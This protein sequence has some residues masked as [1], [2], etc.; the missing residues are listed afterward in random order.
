MK[1]EPRPAIHMENSLLTAWVGLQVRWDPP[2]R[3]NHVNQVDGVSNMAPAC[4]LCGS[5]G[6]GLRKGTMA[7]A[8][9]NARHISS[10]LYATGALHAAIPTPGL[11][12]ESE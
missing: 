9:P 2:G 12:S 4:Q 10:S 6:R 1:H 8:H 5:V 7:S 11:R 3:A